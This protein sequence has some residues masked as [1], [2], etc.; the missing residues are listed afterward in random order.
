M[1][2][3]II[4]GLS[5]AGKSRVAAAL[6]D[7]DFY[8]VDNM[9]VTL[10][11]KFA[12]L[13]VAT[14]GRY[15]RV[16][17]VT[18][19]RSRESF[20]ELFESLDELTALGLEYKILYVDATLETIVKRYK[21]TRRRHPLTGEGLSLVEAVQREMR[22]LEPVRSR[23]NYVIDTTGLTLGRLQRNLIR[24][25]GG[26][27]DNKI[28]VT[29]MSFGY[30]YGIPI[31][32]DIVFDVRFLPNPFYVPELQNKTGQSKDVVD[33]V[34]KNGQA[35]EF[36]RRFEGL[37]EYLLPNYEEEGKLSLTVCIGCTGGRHRSVAISEAIAKLFSEKG[38]STECIHRDADKG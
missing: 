26:G 20:D 6:E 25:F 27:A 18:D 9:P 30:K 2:I 11:P 1:D 10:I 13:C 19:V 15:E 28:K 24:I 16:A 37:L 17:L 14:R 31:E 21:E 34:F 33:Y 3:L 38:Y 35:E 4:S 7:L 23:A 36:L 22:M 8:C 12:E 5:G 29:V 32:A